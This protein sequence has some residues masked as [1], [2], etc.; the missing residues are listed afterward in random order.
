MEL[1]TISAPSLLSS[2]TDWSDV[3]KFIKDTAAI[4]SSLTPM[5]EL[6]DQ[7]QQYLTKAKG[8]MAIPGQLHSKLGV[9]QTEMQFLYDFSS[10]LQLFPVFKDFL[11]L[12]TNGLGGEL[13]SIKTL[14]GDMSSF[15]DATSSLS[16]SLMVSN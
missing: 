8:Q 5:I 12:L 1:P 16:T 4:T 3:D 11:P 7:L 15:V 10:F 13:T 14:D 9:L 2:P 6:G